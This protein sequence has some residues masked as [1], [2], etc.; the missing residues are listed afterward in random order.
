MNKVLVILILIATP[1]FSQIITPKKSL[2]IDSDNAIIRDK[3]SLPSLL[4]E[5]TPE[6]KSGMLAVLYSLVLPGMGELYAGS[7][8]SGKYFT[9]AE[10]AIWGAYIGINTY[11][12][13]KRN[14]YKSYAS[15]FGGVNSDN[16]NTDYYA[17]I[18][19]FVNIDDFNREK[20]LG[21]EFNRMYDN[22]SQN[23]WNWKTEAHRREYKI[24]WVSGE[25]AYNNLRFAVGA[26]IVNRVVSAF[27]AVRLVRA[28][29]K[30]M[31]TENIGWNLSIGVSPVANADTDM[32]LNFQTSF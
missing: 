28:Y 19:D 22:T 29:N 31:E 6:K 16:K 10:G 20:A 5:H 4:T 1:V 7:Y 8:Q 32:S 13:W 9:I 26:L 25:Q 27:N 18:G 30:G 2:Y 21:A 12:S 11:S 23:Y 14:S 3:T 24:L 15:S 17:N